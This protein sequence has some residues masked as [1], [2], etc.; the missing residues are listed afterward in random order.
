MGHLCSHLGLTGSEIFSHSV[1]F[2]NHGVAGFFGSA[3]ERH[4]FA[5]LKAAC[6]SGDG[7]VP[8]VFFVGYAHSLGPGIDTP[9]DRYLLGFVM[10]DQNRCGHRDGR[11]YDHDSHDDFGCG[12]LQAVCP[13]RR[14]RHYNKNGNQDSAPEK[15]SV[16]ARPFVPSLPRIQ[17]ENVGPAPR[18]VKDNVYKELLDFLGFPRKVGRSEGKLLETSLTYLR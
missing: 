2:E 8:V 4:A 11:G 1:K 17:F 16:H 7:V 6:A 15:S 9:G 18:F 12:R 13:R 3:F 14:C 5:S 10:N